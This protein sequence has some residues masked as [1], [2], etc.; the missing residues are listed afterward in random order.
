MGTFRVLGNAIGGRL[1]DADD[2]VVRSRNRGD[3][4]AGPLALLGAAALANLL[5]QG[6]EFPRYNN[7]FHVAIVLDY[8]GS[9]EGPHDLFHQTLGAFVSVLWPLLACV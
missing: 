3:V 2:R 9:A 8:A 7:I 6:F 1:G 5:L 4:I